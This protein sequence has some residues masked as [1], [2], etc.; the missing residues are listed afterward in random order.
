MIPTRDQLIAIAG[1]KP[2]VSN[3][4][5]IIV[6]LDRFGGKFGLDKPHRLAHFISQL[7]HESGNFRYD[8]E[9]ASGAAY[10]GRKDLGNT[11]PGDGKRFKGR[12][13]IQITGRANYAAFTKWCRNNIGPEAPDFVATPDAINT[14]PW[15]GIAPIWYWAT[16]KLNDYADENN[17][18]QITKKINGGL[19]AFDDRIAKYVR[20][21]LVLLGYAPDDV[22]GFQ[23]DAQAAGF[24]PK[25]E[26]GKRPQV[27]GDAGPVT[28]S[29]MHMMMA[30]KV[31][32]ISAK[33][34]TPAPVVAEVPVEVPVVPKGADKPGI[35]RWLGSIPLLGA[36]IMAFVD[37]DIV[38]KGVILGAVVIGI[39]AL[40]WRGEQIAA[41]ARAVIKSFEG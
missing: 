34:V 33:P 10:E 19:N 13:P 36:P 20:A 21:G 38:T 24:L 3:V 18:E 23:K 27:D 32:V 7:A 5:S 28:R 2:N 40:L 9:I 22:R 16:R 15:E 31:E 12:G 25:D 30:D 8:E 35:G 14:D 39:V 26:P 11:E 1:G 6:A 29:A 41:R 4:N 37:M 17:L